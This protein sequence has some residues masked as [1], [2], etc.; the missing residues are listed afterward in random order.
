MLSFISSF[1]SERD[2]LAYMGLYKIGEFLK[3]HF[4]TRK[5]GHYIHVWVYTSKT[6]FCVDLIF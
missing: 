4:K 1:P 5:H 3:S 2:K 6:F